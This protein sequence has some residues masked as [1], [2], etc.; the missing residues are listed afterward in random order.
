MIL[1]FDTET[2]G[3]RPGQICQLSYIMQSGESLESRNLFFTVDYMEKSAEMVH[4]FSIEKLQALSNGKRFCDY[5]DV[6]EKDFSSADL[7]VAHNSSFDFSFMRAEYERLGKIFSVKNEFCSMKKS[8][9]ICKLIRASSGAYKYPKLSELC[10][11]F[12]IDNE[13]I[14]DAL[15]KVFGASAG[16]HDARFD[17]TAVL[18]AINKGIREFGEYKELVKYL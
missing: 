5:I 3:L 4:G 9:P 12:A 6:I 16:F 1:F 2:T 7:V 18:L 11:H 17:A 14:S 13:Q 8:V 10:A 15:F